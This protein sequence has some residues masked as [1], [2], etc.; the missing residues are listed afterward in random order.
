VKPWASFSGGDCSRPRWSTND[1]DAR[2]RAS[3]AAVGRRPAYAAAN[4]PRSFFTNR[5]SFPLSAISR[6]I[7]E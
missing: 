4:W 6:M 5:A 3:C 2:L 7:A 1:K